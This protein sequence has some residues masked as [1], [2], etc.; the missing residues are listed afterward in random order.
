M[1]L[2]PKGSLNFFKANPKIL[3]SQTFPRRDEWLRLI[4]EHV[5]TQSACTRPAQRQL[6]ATVQSKQFKC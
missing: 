5:R 4:Q 3:L 1:R 6:C 2:I